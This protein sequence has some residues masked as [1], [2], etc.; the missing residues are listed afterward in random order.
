M[1]RSSHKRK[2]TVYWCPHSGTAVGFENDDWA[3]STCAHPYLFQN[4]HWA[5]STSWSAHHVAGQLPCHQHSPA[6]PGVVGS[7]DSWM[8]SI[9]QLSESHTTCWLR[10]AM[11]RWFKPMQINLRCC[12]HQIDRWF[13]PS[14]IWVK[15]IDQSDMNNNNN[16]PAC[17]SWSL[18]IT[19]NF[20]TTIVWSWWHGMGVA[21]LPLQGGSQTLPKN[22]G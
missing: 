11:R 2:K 21:D 17:V 14:L 10:R 18:D 15:S 1:M 8:Q 12:L 16:N 6:P 4:D 13:S 19:I 22:L 5:P 3:P 9:Y 7:T 20:W